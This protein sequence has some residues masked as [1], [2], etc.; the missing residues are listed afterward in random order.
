MANSKR[1]ILSILFLCLIINNV[2]PYKFVESER[3]AAIISRNLVKE[4]GIGTLVTLMNE[5]EKEDVR[6]I[7]LKD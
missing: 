6:G 3:D 5:Y 4:F 2:N 7:K 1:L